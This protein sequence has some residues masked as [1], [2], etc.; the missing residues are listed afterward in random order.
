MSEALAEALTAEPAPV[1][2]DVPVDTGPTEDEALGAA[3]DRLMTNNGSDR[4]ED[5]KF[6]STNPDKAASPGGEDGAGDGDAA[7][8]ASDTSPAPANWNGLD[9]AWKA[10]PA[11]LQAKVKPH[12]EDLHRRM[13]DQGRQ[14]ASVKPFADHMAQA[15]QAIPTFKGM[16]PE[17]VSQ[18][19]L[20]LA[21]VA[22]ELKRDPVGTL[23]N[24]AHST[25]QLEALAAKLSGQAMP[26]GTQQITDLKREIASLKNQLQQAADPSQIET[27][28]SR[29]FEGRAA[30][31]AVNQ[32]AS[33]PANSFFADVEPQMPAFITL[34]K[35][36]KPGAPIKD[37]LQ[38]AYDMAI[39]ALPEVRAKVQAAVKSAAADPA[40]TEAAKKA[41]SINVKSNSTGKER[42]L[43]E[44]ESLGS[45]Y[46][47][48]MAS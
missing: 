21:A 19:A 27:Q 11:D 8:V 25:G 20:E 33:D 37:V 39:N 1:V 47:R 14:L 45:A 10:L 43:T 5:G 40:R 30:Q 17:Q 6:V 24:I 23:I 44:A 13:S 48:A 3:F 31:E 29:V 26:E 35:E 15:T 4:G 42:V 18:K 34:A 41:A 9:D 12:F 16:A 28:V 36:A 7:T 22:V 2:V 32:F 38:T 46:D